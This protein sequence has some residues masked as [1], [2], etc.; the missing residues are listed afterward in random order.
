MHH[1]T[2]AS[3]LTKPNHGAEKHVEATHGGKQED[4]TKLSL[5]AQMH[6]KD[7]SNLWVKGN[8]K[9]GTGT[10]HEYS[11]LKDDVTSTGATSH[12][13]AAAMKKLSDSNDKAAAGI[14]QTVK[15]NSSLRKDT[16]TVLDIHDKLKPGSAYGLDKKDLE[17][18][19]ALPKQMLTDAQRDSVKRVLKDWDKIDDLKTDG[20]IK[21][22]DRD[23]EKKG[24]DKRQADVDKQ[25]AQL[26]A[27]KKDLAQMTKDQ[28]ADD[29]KAEQAQLDIA[30]IQDVLK[31]SQVHRGDGFYQ[32]A[33]RMLNTDHQKHDD[34]EIKALTKVLQD[35]MAA[36]GVKPKLNDQLVTEANFDR[37]MQK[38]RGTDVP[39][40]PVPNL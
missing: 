29:K 38:I 7:H 23:S 30:P 6:L 3:D 37:I 34:K 25:S 31:A 27:S 33:Q 10:P 18:M 19:A 4:S 8:T 9:D 15:D 16:D 20:P 24:F 1:D 22:L 36:E 28:Q 40:L 39:S 11:Q 12:D 26:D 5:E 2:T 17:Q 32:V 35:E 21:L 14:D 13:H